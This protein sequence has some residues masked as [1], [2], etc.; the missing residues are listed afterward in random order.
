[1]TQGPP[2]SLLVILPQVKQAH[3]PSSGRWPFCV[4]ILMY[5]SV[6]ESLSLASTQTFLFFGGSGFELRAY[7]LARP[8]EPLHRVFCV[9]VCDGFFKTG[10][11][12]LFAQLVSNYDPCQ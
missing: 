11:L 3:C 10:S 12:E 7:M 2:L 9:C 4:V 6:Y 8:L 1:V 5:M